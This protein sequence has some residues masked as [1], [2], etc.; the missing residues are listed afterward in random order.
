MKHLLI[1]AAL[2][3][4]APAMA[5]PVTPGA[6][7]AE[8]GRDGVDKVRDRL[9][10]MSFL[11][12]EER[13]A[14]AGVEF[15]SGLQGVYQWR[16]ANG[17]GPMGGLF[18]GAGAELPPGGPQGTFRPESFAETMQATIAAMD[19]AAAALRGLPEAGEFALDV[20]FADLWLDVNANGVRDPG[21][22]VAQLFMGETMGFA[23]EG[24]A[25]PVI[26]FDRADSAWLLAYTRLVSGMGEFIFAFDPT[27]VIAKVSAAGDEIAAARAA[28]PDAFAF[29]SFDGFIGPVSLVMGTLAQQ[30]DAT[31]TRAARDRWQDMIATNRLF[32]D[33]V[34]KETDNDG[35]WIPNARQTSATGLPFPPDTG[36]VWQTVLDDGAALLD[37]SRSIPFWRAPIGLS[38]ADW[39]DNPAP[40]PLDGVLQGWAVLPYRTDAPPISADNLRRF[41]DLMTDTGPFLSMVMIN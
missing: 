26:R 3:L 35:E 7:S 6:I 5:A 20:G 40:L 34:T 2:V 18:F 28:W 9:R 25:L 15:L 11:T 24:T 27:P 14:L 4:A 38:L 33:L 21:E 17:I 19:R 22:D 39:L 32:W 36:P 13:F 37:G 41:M 30:P 8:I 16:A 29:G 23:P 1:G 31:R 10:G 12:S